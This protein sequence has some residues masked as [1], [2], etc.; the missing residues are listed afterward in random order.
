MGQILVDHSALHH[1]VLKTVC[2]SL[3]ESR[4]LLPVLAPCTNPQ[5][6]HQK[7]VFLCS[8]AKTP[9]LVGTLA[10]P[11][12]R[13]EPNCSLCWKPETDLEAQGHFINSDTV[14]WLLKEQS[15]SFQSAIKEALN[16]DPLETCVYIWLSTPILAPPSSAVTG[17]LRSSAPLNSV[18]ISHPQNSGSLRG[19]GEI[20]F[21]LWFKT[22][23]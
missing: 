14:W 8:V 11:T 21:C 10:E 17:K 2:S 1:G 16:P 6:H 19:F 3:H 22:H 7:R 12:V 9:D 13:G 23:N 20:K 4:A 5:P 18:P 15:R